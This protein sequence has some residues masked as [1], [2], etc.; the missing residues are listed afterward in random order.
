MANNGPILEV[1]ANLKKFPYQEYLEKIER[2]DYGE[3][4]SN[5]TI[6][7]LKKKA[8]EKL[9]IIIEEEQQPLIKESPL[10]DEDLPVQKS[11]LRSG[12]RQLIETGK[13]RI[14]SKP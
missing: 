3:E 1:S 11:S 10:I 12:E 8:Q 5:K 9:G 13:F 2:A 6:T 7:H 4:F 14:D